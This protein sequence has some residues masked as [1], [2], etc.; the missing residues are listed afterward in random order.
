M[1]GTASSTYQAPLFKLKSS[2][3]KAFVQMIWIQLLAV[4]NSSIRTSKAF[5]CPLHSWKA[6]NKLL[7]SICVEPLGRCAVVD[8]PR[9][10][11]ASYI[12][13]SPTFQTQVTGRR[14]NGSVQSILA[15]I[16]TLYTWKAIDK[17]LVFAQYHFRDAPSQSCQSLLNTLYTLKVTDEVKLAMV[18]L[19]G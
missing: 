19:F 14:R 15:F 6:I 9:A 2:G 1:T 7:A 18:S 16:N 8:H 12:H 11:R 10:V 17:L 13:C 3:N 5:T 4:A